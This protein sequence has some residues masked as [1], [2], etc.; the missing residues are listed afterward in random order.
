MSDY[1]QPVIIG[2]Q[3][4]D[5]DPQKRTVDKVE[6][7]ADFPIDDLRDPRFTVGFLLTGKVHQ[8]HVQFRVGGDSLDIPGRAERGPQGLMA[9]DELLN[10]PPQG[11]HLE[12]SAQ[13]DRTRFVVSGGHRGAHLS[14]EPYL[15]LRIGQG[16]GLHPC[17]HGPVAADDRI[18]RTL[19][20][21]W[22]GRGRRRNGRLSRVSAL[23]V[24][25]GRE[26]F[27][28]W[29]GLEQ[30]AKSDVDA[31]PRLDGLAGLGEKQ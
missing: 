19:I 9:A 2:G 29:K 4:D 6:F 25:P 10:R 23:S 24:D 1:D 22:S 3:P 21:P 12:R 17:L 8:R 28:A 13:T 18:L 20:G 7:V 5:L 11:L 16:N 14:S 30:L 15:A 31:E 26:F 27:Q